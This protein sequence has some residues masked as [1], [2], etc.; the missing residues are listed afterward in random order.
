MAKLRIF[1]LSVEKAAEALG[2]S[3]ASAFRMWTYARAWLT[4]ALTNKSENR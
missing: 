1:G 3:R 4:A 2:L